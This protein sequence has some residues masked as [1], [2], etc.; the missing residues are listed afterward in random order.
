MSLNVL[1][2][3]YVVVYALQLLIQAFLM[4]KIRSSKCPR[5]SHPVLGIQLYPVASLK[6]SIIS[7]LSYYPGMVKGLPLSNA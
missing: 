4:L 6:L 5:D 3:M 1:V 7:C 2:C